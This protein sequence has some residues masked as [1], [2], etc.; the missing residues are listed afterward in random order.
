[1]SRNLRIAAICLV[2]VAIVSVVALV[3]AFRGMRSVPPYYQQALELDEDVLETGSREFEGRATALY[4]DSQ[5]IGSWQATFTADQ[6]NSWLADQFAKNLADELPDQV[7]EPRVAISRNDITLGFRSHVGWTDAVVSV[8]ASVYVTESG[9]IA[10]HL[11]SV[12]AG[13]VP[14]P[15]LQVA[16]ELAK[17]C[18]SLSLPVRWTRHDNQPVAMIDLSLEPGSDEQHMVI[19]LIEVEDGALYVAGHTAAGAAIR[20]VEA[21]NAP[22]QAE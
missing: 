1:M 3:A 11:K 8:T 4:S 19:D 15:V 6:I 22:P 16:D 5:K 7:R 17:A 13:S 9:A 20:P 2:I 14:M 12:H 21:P 10:V 18:Q